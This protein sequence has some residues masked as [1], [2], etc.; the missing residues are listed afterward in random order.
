MYPGAS[1]NHFKHLIGYRANKHCFVT[2]CIRVIE[3][4]IV[5]SMQNHA[6]SKSTL[7]MKHF[8]GFTNIFVYVWKLLW[9][10]V[11]MLI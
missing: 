8:M 9:T 5:R 11:H 4:K 2:M 3:N 6:G 1:H 10:P 7:A